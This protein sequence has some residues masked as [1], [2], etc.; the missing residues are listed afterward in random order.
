MHFAVFIG[1]NQ[2]RHHWQAE[3]KAS[4]RLSFFLWIGTNLGPYHRSWALQHRLQGLR[5]GSTTWVVLHTCAL[6]TLL[7]RLVHFMLSEATFICSVFSALLLLLQGDQ[8]TGYTAISTALILSQ[9]QESLDT[10]DA[11]G[12]SMARSKPKVTAAAKQATSAAAAVNQ[13]STQLQ[14]VI[15]KV[16]QS[17]TQQQQQEPAV[18][19]AVVV[20]SR[21]QIVAVLEQQVQQVNFGLEEMLLHLQQEQQ[22]W[23]H[24][25]TAAAAASEVVQQYSRAADTEDTQLLLTA[26]VEPEY[27]GSLKSTLQQLQAAESQLSRVLHRSGSSSCG[28]LSDKIIVTAE[29]AA[30]DISAM[31]LELSRLLEGY[32]AGNPPAKGPAAGDSLDNSDVSRRL[33]VAAVRASE[34]LQVR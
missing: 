27:Y 6:Q 21:Q 4:A 33:E 12:R 22:R 24:V 23:Q 9:L 10:L 34:K 7:Y 31:L 8:A 13:I 3:D 16:Q 20:S 29:S 28:D 17:H 32:L 19:V 1:S 15:G 14:Q 11:T 26:G 30:R 18:L 25:I 2:C 5:V